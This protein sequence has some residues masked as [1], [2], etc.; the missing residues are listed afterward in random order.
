[1]AAVADEVGYS[2]RRLSTLVKEETG[3]AP[4]EYQRVARFEAS[5]A[6]CSGRRPLAEVAAECGYADQAHLAARVV[7]AGRLPAEH[8]AARGVPIPPRPGAADAAG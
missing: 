8:L 3:L 2:R 4:K 7:R 6:R 1:M 5:R